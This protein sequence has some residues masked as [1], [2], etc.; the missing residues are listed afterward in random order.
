MQQREQILR[1]LVMAEEIARLPRLQGANLIYRA[2]C[3]DSCVDEQHAAGL[4]H[5][6][7]QFRHELMNDKNANAGH[8]PRPQLFGRSMG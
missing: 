1:Q 2:P 6:F 3:I 5:F 4:F 8:L 7:N